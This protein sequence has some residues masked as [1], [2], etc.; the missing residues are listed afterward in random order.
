MDKAA[1]FLLDLGITQV[2]RQNYLGEQI[3]T[4]IDIPGPALISSTS[5]HSTARGPTPTRSPE[6]ALPAR[7]DY[8]AFSAF[9][10]SHPIPKSTTPQPSLFQQQQI[11]AAAP[12]PAA[13]APAVD[14]FAALTSPMRNATPQQQPQKSIFDFANPQPPAAPA[15]VAAAADD[16]EWAFSSALPEVLPASNALTVSDTS[17]LISLHAARE[18]ATTDVITLSLSFS[19]KTAE[20]IS[21]LTFMAAV[22]KVCSPRSPPHPPPFPSTELIRMKIGILTQTPTPIR[23]TTPAQRTSR[24]K[25]DHPSKWC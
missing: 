3:L 7:P 24:R 15:P 20:P 12:K 14:P 11:A 21:E 18:L 16:D 6:P 9:G 13:P 22:T 10:S 25:A 2:S 23:S 17:L 19:N 1:A 8:S 4:I 5:E